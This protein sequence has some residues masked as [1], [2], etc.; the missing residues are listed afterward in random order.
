MPKSRQSFIRFRYNKA[1]HRMSILLCYVLAGYVNIYD[2][3]SGV[4]SLT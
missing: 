4:F 1:L 3:V 2:L